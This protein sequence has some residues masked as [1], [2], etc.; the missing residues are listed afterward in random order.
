[1]NPMMFRRRRRYGAVVALCGTTAASSVQRSVWMSS[2]SLERWGP[3]GNGSEIS[4]WSNCHHSVFSQLC[5]L[6]M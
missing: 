4:G 6:V 3:D 1:M 5:T 2:R